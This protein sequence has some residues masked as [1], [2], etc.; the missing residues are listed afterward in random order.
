MVAPAVVVESVIV[1][2]ETTSPAAGFTVGVA[3]VSGDGGG[4]FDAG[5]HPITAKP[6][7]ATMASIPN[8]NSFFFILPSLD[9]K[10]FAPISPRS[11]FIFD[12]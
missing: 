1:V 2:P 10:I 11:T 9:K 4:F 12:A 5:S 3:T 7:V 6:N 8:N